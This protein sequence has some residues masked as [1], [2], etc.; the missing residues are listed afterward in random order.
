MI[1][2]RLDNPNRWLELIRTI[3]TLVEITPSASQVQ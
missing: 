1:G 3:V 2:Q